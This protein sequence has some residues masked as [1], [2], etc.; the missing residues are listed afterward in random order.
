VWFLD[1]ELESRPPADW[2]EDAR[3]YLEQF[4][5]LHRPYVRGLPP[6]GQPSAERVRSALT[7]HGSSTWNDADFQHLLHNLGC[8]GYGWLRPEGVQRKLQEMAAEWTS[9]PPLFTE[10]PAS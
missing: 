6:S 2:D 8:A 4:L 10:K 5:F 1:W 7:R 3:P 9:P